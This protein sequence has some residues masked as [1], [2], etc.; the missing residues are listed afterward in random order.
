MTVWTYR[1]YEK[2]QK[3]TFCLQKNEED[4]FSVTR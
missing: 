2:T 1:Y 3:L 4:S